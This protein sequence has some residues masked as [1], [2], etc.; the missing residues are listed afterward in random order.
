[1]RWRRGFQQINSVKT[2]SPKLYT[3]DNVTYIGIYD[4]LY[5]PIV[6]S[7]EDMDNCKIEEDE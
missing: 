2:E 3:C 4:D 1:M 6:E 5:L 7:E